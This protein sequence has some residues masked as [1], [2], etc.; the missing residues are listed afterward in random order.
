MCL[1]DF[2]VHFASLYVCKLPAPGWHETIA[3]SCWLGTSAGGCS[4]HRFTWPNNPPFRLTIRKPTHV[5]VALAQ[6]DNRGA[7][8][9]EPFAIG[10]SL[11]HGVRNAKVQ[12]ADTGAFSPVREVSFDAKLELRGGD[13]TEYVLRPSTFNPGEEVGFSL[14]IYSDQPVELAQK[15]GAGGSWE[16]V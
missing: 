10:V 3:R 9:S 2:I 14:R 4:N 1:D 15:S 12:G 16:L 7:E 8:R 5:L 6:D 13:K 11:M